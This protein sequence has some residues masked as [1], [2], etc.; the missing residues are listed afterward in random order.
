MLKV[1]QSLLQ[2]FSTSH[3]ANVMSIHAEGNTHSTD[4]LMSAFVNELAPAPCTQSITSVRAAVLNNYER[5]HT[6]KHTQ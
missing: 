4:G 1:V 3:K 5:D 6:C 2:S